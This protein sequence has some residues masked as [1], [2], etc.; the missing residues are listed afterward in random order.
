M[1]KYVQNQIKENIHLSKKVARVIFFADRL[2][3][4][5]PFLLSMDALNVYQIDIYQSLILI[6]KAHAGTALSIFFDKFSKINHNYPTS[7]KNK[8]S[9]TILE[10]IIKLTN[11]EISRRGPIL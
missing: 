7:S 10:S 8:G 1:G 11:F 5:K 9:Y 4:V 6:Y 3:H 2:A